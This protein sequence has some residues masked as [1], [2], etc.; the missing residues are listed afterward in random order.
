MENT[1]YFSSCRIFKIAWEIYPCPWLFPMTVA[2]AH[3]SHRQKFWAFIDISQLLFKQLIPKSNA[4]LLSRS[5][6]KWR[7]Y[8]SI[9]ALAHALLPTDVTF[10]LVIISWNFLRL[11]ALRSTIL[12][13]MGSREAC[14]STRWK[15]SCFVKLFFPTSLSTTASSRFRFRCRIWFGWNTILY[16]DMGTKI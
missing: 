6:N 12:G 13:G 4:L 14:N 2:L 1:K 9:S 8:D 11:A 7:S 15:N 3:H 10:W 16:T 5:R